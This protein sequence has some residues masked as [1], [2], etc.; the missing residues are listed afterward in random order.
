VLGP[1]GR[2]ETRWHDRVAPQALAVKAELDRLTEALRGIAAAHAPGTRVRV[3][4]DQEL[5][6]YL[7]I[8]HDEPEAVGIVAARARALVLPPWRLWHNDRNLAILPPFLGKEHAVSWL[9]REVF[10]AG[11]LCIGVGDSLSDLPFLAQCDFAMMPSGSQL[12]RALGTP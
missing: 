12:L 9:R 4:M 6:L 10:G 1:E 2:L 8:K 7:S 11:T 3:I 5:P